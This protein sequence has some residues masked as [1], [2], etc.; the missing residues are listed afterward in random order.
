MSRSVDTDRA[1][2][3]MKLVVSSLVIPV[4]GRI[5]LFEHVSLNSSLV[6]CDRHRQYSNYRRLVRKDQV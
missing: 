2:Y 5:Y 6:Y 3:D 4:Q 1:L